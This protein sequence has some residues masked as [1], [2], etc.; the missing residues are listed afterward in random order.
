M[1]PELSATRTGAVLILAPDL[2]SAAHLPD[3]LL[4]RD[5]QRAAVGKCLAAAVRGGG[6]HAWLVGPP[7]SGK[8]TVARHA[9]AAHGREGARVVV[10]DAAHAATTHQVLDAILTKL[11]Q[12]PRACD[13][14]AK[15]RSLTDPQRPAVIVLL[16][17]IEAMAAPERAR[18]ASILLALPKTSLVFVSD[19][20]G[21]AQA[22]P[23]FVFARLCARLIRFQ[24]YTQAELERILARRAAEALRPDA[25]QPAAV[26]AIARAATGDVG[27]GIELIHRAALWAE[28][29]GAGVLDAAFVGEFLRDHGIPSRGTTL[30]GLPADAAWAYEF[31]ETARHATSPEV[32]V[33]LAAHCKA[34][35]RRPPTRRSV[36]RY[37]RRLADRGLVH[38]GQPPSATESVQFQV[39]AGAPGLEA[40]P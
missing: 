23:P 9:A 17:G 19:R 27:L 28:Q 18:C 16:E 38:A 32:H 34:E 14:P 7:G 21:P 12:V 30:R 25:I 29:V 35:G 40:A 2:L 20:L 8:R 13:L 11:G 3:R 36:Q 26:T 5:V 6:L 31:L 4:G 15:I 39:A 24:P 22:L 1:T 10:I 37:L 33:A